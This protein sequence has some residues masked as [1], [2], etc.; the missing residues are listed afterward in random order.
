MGRKAIPVANRKQQINV[1]LPKDIINKIDAIQTTCNRSQMFESL[2]RKGLV[3]WYLQK[4]NPDWT[5]APM[6]DKIEQMGG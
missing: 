2:L 1:T 6:M 3:V 4:Q 5:L